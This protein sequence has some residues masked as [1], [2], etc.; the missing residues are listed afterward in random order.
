MTL[1]KGE[2]ATIKATIT[3]YNKKKTLI[4][5]GHSPLLRYISSNTAVAKVNAN[6]TVYGVGSGYCK[7]YVQTVNGLWKTVSVTVN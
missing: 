5:S 4:D 1:K 7:V 6:G 3:K 2:K